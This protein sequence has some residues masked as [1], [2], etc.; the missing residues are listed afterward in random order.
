MVYPLKSLQSAQSEPAFD[1]K[2]LFERELASRS[3]SVW[4][5]WGVLHNVFREI[6][7]AASTTDVTGVPVNVNQLVSDAVSSFI[8]RLTPAIVEQ[9]NDHVSG[10]SDDAYYVKGLEDQLVRG[11]LAATREPFAN[12]SETVVSAA[13]EFA[14]V[15]DA[16]AKAMNTYAQRAKD[17]AEFRAVKDGRMISQA[18]IAKM[19]AA[20][21]Q[22]TTAKG[23]MDSVHSA[24]MALVDAAT[25]KPKEEPAILSAAS[26]RLRKL[27]LEYARTQAASLG[28]AV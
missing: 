24:L 16:F 11:M 25:P 2:G 22:I 8:A 14:Q 15:A 17:K 23:H 9:I 10:D 28:V 13:Q 12:H 6:A 18:N 19:S 20:C 26:E 5:L 3:Q 7:K 4:D 27:R 21:E 1:V